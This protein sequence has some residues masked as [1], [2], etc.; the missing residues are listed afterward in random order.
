MIMN[1]ACFHKTTHLHEQDKH[2][3]SI[4]HLKINFVRMKSLKN[5]QLALLLLVTVAFAESCTKS[6]I[7]TSALYTP[8]AADVTSNATLLELQKGRDL[9]INNCSTCHS[10][11]SP[12]SYSATQWKTVINN[13]APRTGMASSD[14][15]LV[16]K[17]VSRGKQ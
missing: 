1:R 9:Y 4:R 7:D 16:S 13:M 2:A 6:T 14:I 10:L 11:F 17:Y 15:L 5:Y 3:S 8:T 12:D